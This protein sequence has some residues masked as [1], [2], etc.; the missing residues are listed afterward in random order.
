MINKAVS[1]LK[2]AFLPTNGQ[3]Y[4][5]NPHQNTIMR[6]KIR[7]AL[8][9]NPDDNERALAVV[10]EKINGLEPE[11]FEPHDWPKLAEFFAKFRLCI[12]RLNPEYQVKIHQH[13]KQ[14]L[15][16][17][18]KNKIKSKTYLD[19]TIVSEINYLEIFPEQD[20]IELAQHFMHKVDRPEFLSPQAEEKGERRNISGQTNYDDRLFDEIYYLRNYL[21]NDNVVND[22]DYVIQT[23]IGHMQKSSNFE[24]INPCRQLVRLCDKLRKEHIES[25]LKIIERSR[26]SNE[27]Y[28]TLAMCD[29]L[30]A[31][32]NDENNRL[33]EIN[34]KLIDKIIRLLNY[35]D[36]FDRENST[37]LLLELPENLIQIFNNLQH[38]ISQ[39]NKNKISEQYLKN[40][41]FVTLEKIYDIFE[42][43][44]QKRIATK[45]AGFIASIREHEEY[46]MPVKIIKK[47]DTII[48]DNTR[49]VL[50]GGM[51]LQSGIDTKIK[52]W[53]CNL[54]I[55][56]FNL[57]SEKDKASA[58]DNIFLYIGENISELI[59]NNVTSPH[60]TPQ[61]IAVLKQHVPAEGYWLS[62]TNCILQNL[63]ADF[64][65]NWRIIH[66]AGNFIPPAKVDEIIARICFYIDINLKTTSDALDALTGFSQITSINSLNLIYEKIK[67]FV[68]NDQSKTFSQRFQIYYALLTIAKTVNEDRLYV[69]IY[70]KIYEYM[71]KVSVDERKTIYNLL[72]NNKQNTF[73]HEKIFNLVIED[74]KSKD[75][76]NVAENFLVFLSKENPKAPYGRILQVLI[77]K[78][79]LPFAHVAHYS[80][81]TQNNFVRMAEN[82][83][84]DEIKAAVAQLKIYL[85]K[86][87]Y[88]DSKMTYDK[89][90]NFIPI[91]KIFLR[92]LDHKDRMNFAC[93]L[94]HDCDQDQT[95]YLA[96][97]HLSAVDTM[98]INQKH[99]PQ[100]VVSIINQFN[101]LRF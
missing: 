7:N 67:Q 38:K 26:G 68:E 16:N 54:I 70:D 94:P 33:A 84:G 22:F 25:I 13:I 96:A 91:I 24:L 74:T 27:E 83:N 37:S 71:N 19:T 101:S 59:N 43:K 51:I 89:I 47:L 28:T 36:K 4:F 79:D 77:E 64:R 52:A 57:I 87:H 50:I 20:L 69:V 23:L 99:V 17:D 29:L 60:T 98:L 78:M 62:L 48:D 41:D 40:S 39:T 95:L 92:R 5:A 9:D 35:N 93:Y 55:H 72:T 49:A 12:L 86:Y 66:K 46:I 80:F 58:T 45:Y 11:H 10:I 63:N 2:A 81:H 15:F 82:M 56:N 100:P 73:I 88:G 14:K 85:I 34:D 31:L 65:R 32:Q 61:M 3:R 21:R 18:L 30:V 42:E 8:R 97:Y 6:A 44:H 76:S 90:E 53:R 1:S 75:Y